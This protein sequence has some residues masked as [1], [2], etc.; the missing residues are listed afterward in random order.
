MTAVDEDVDE[1]DTGGD[2]FKEARLDE[3]LARLDAVP[4]IP[5]TLGNFEREAR[6]HFWRFSNRLQQGRL[7]PEQV[8]RVAAYYDGV[9]EKHP[10]A[11]E[12]IDDEIFVVRNLVLGNVAPN[13]V[14][15]DTD[16]SA[17]YFS[18]TSCSGS[19]RTTM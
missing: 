2:F 11:A 4:G 12:M 15:T 7:A 8:D 19:T 16:G 1:F 13:I 17:A 3:M 9:K 14:G 5:E 18:S 10:D 6:I